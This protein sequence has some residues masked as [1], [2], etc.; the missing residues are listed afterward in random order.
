MLLIKYINKPSTSADIAESM[1]K[2]ALSLMYA[3][4][5]NIQ[6]KTKRQIEIIDKPLTA[7]SVSS[8]IE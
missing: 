5:D 7:S 3:I 2:R 6:T 1:E 4:K 8:E